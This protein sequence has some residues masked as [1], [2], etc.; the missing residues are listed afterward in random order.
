M[1]SLR[2]PFDGVYPITQ[3][4]NEH[5]QR[6]KYSGWC[7]KPGSCP[8]GIY[9]YG[10]IDYA[11]PLETHL[12]AASAGVITKVVNQPAGYGCAVYQ[13]TPDGYTIIYAH[14]L[15][16]GIKVL[17]GDKL[18]TGDPIGESGSTGN[19]TGPHLHFEIRDK[20]GLAVNPDQFFGGVVPPVKTNQ[21]KTIKATN[22][23][24]VPKILAA[25]VIGTVRPDFTIEVTGKRIDTDGY[26]WL[27]CFCYV[28]EILVTDA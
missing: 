2:L 16:G 28:A 5:I 22:I 17:V 6:A 20:T 7:W 9:Y 26:T 13:L 24:A 18:F 19:S 27:Q 11:C 23:R 10:G 3:T 12:M 15:E 14:M 25:N 21:V 4:Y 1:P 8:S